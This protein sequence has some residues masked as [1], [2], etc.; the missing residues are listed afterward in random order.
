MPV[1]PRGVS[2]MPL[3]IFP[4]SK[5]G[6][7]AAV[8]V[9]K[10]AALIVPL[11]IFP[12]SKLGISA[13]TRLRNVGAP[14]AVPEE[15]PAKI[16]FG[17]CVFHAKLSVPVSVTGDPA[18]RN[19]AEGAERPTELTVPPPPEDFEVQESVPSVSVVSTSP[20]A[21]G[22]ATGKVKVFAPN[23]ICRFG[24][25]T[26]LSKE[27][28]SKKV[29]SEEVRLISDLRLLVGLFKSEVKP[30]SNFGRVNRIKSFVP[31][32]VVLILPPLV[33]KSFA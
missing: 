28:F 22:A 16:S 33:R 9:G 1:P 29:T 10:R 26:S 31:S 30:T 23:F 21:A 6:I 2:K 19:S 7:S 15:G 12:A 11:V 17:C 3:V 4:A 25:E 18:T 5:F 20:S 14:A 24:M 8:R 13:A 27:V 32:P